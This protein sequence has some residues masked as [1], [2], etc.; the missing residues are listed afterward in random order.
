MRGLHAH[1]WSRV[2]LEPN[3][4]NQ[5]T[6]GKWIDVDLTPPSWQS[7]EAAITDGWRQRLAD[8][9]QLT[10]ED[11]LIWRTKEANKTRVLYV[12]AAILS[13]VAIWVSWRLWSSRQRNTDTQHNPYQRP[14]NAPYTPLHKLEPLIAKKIGRRPTGTPLCEWLHGLL[15]LDAALSHD[16]EKLL[17][18]A[19]KLHSAIRFDPA[20]SG[21]EKLQELRELS[22]S[23]KQQIKHYPPYK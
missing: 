4:A 19:I 10:R 8:W 20:E 18:P 9:W 15:L 13:L 23:L 6:T 7:I 14:K 21:S 5:I 22:L 1:A 3:A 2:W 11:F 17:L 16:L 12:V